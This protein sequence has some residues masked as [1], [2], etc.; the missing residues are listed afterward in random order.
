VLLA[1]LCL[2][3][4]LGPG[5][6]VG[7]LTVIVGAEAVRRPQIFVFAALWCAKPTVHCLERSKDG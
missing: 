6:I 2:D 3:E 1:Y 4:P 5:T 7:G